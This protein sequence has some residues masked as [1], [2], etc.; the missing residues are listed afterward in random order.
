MEFF[1]KLLKLSLLIASLFLSC[2][3]IFATPANAIAKSETKIKGIAVIGDS[4]SDEYQYDNNRG[5][6]YKNTTLNWVE[7]LSKYRDVNFGKVGDRESPRR[8]GFEYNFAKSSADTNDILE[9]GQVD[10]VV[11]YIN[12]G[13]ISHVIIMIGANDVAPWTITYP[14]IYS[15]KLTKVLLDKRKTTIINNLE[16]SLDKLLDAR[17]VDILLVT[18]PDVGELPYFKNLYANKDKRK[19][20]S[21]FISGLN[22]DIQKMAKDKSKANPLHKKIVVADFNSF[23]RST[24]RKI[25]KKQNIKIAKEIINAKNGGDAPNNL[26]LKDRV[27]PG[28]VLSGMIANFI[29]KTFNSKY[30]TDIKSFTNQELLENAGILN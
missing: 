25:D 17:D 4:V 23:M 20:V 21:T 15:G 6:K 28:T 24:I 14:L 22:K 19:N 9:D 10:G 12:D 5:G 1:I 2:F 16:E 27:H 3:I 26:F 30:K 18:V 7:L 29:T 11:E 8:S 13:K